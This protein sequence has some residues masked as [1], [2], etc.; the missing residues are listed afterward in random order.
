MYNCSISSGQ[1]P[2][3]K[4]LD[5][6]NIV[7]SKMDASTSKIDDIKQEPLESLQKVYN[8]QDESNPD[9]LKKI[10]ALR[11]SIE[12][13]SFERV[14]K[15][16]KKLCDTDT[17]KKQKIISSLVPY[18]NIS[19]LAFAVYKG[20]QRIL[21][22]FMSIFKGNEKYLRSELEKVQPEGTTLLHIAARKNSSEII[23]AYL[24]L[25]EP[26]MLDTL[27]STKDIEER[28]LLFVAAENG[29]KESIVF[30]LEKLSDDE[31]I[32]YCQEA[33]YKGDTPFSIAIRNKK[34]ESLEA[35]LSCNPKVSIAQH[36]KLTDENGDNCLHSVVGN[37]E[38]MN[39]LF[40]HLTADDAESL[41][42][43][44][45]KNQLGNTPL[46]AAIR[47]NQECIEAL[48]N[49]MAA[50]NLDLGEGDFIGFTPLH[51]AALNGNVNVFK[52]YLNN[53][54]LLL[55]KKDM[56]GFSPIDWCRLYQEN[57]II[58]FL[59]TEY[60]SDID[61]NIDSDAR[62]III[63]HKTIKNKFIAYFK[64]E[65]K[66][67]E[68]LL[69]TGSRRHLPFCFEWNDIIK[70]WGIKKLNLGLAILHAIYENDESDKFYRFLKIIAQ[71][72]EKSP[73]LGMSLIDLGYHD[74]ADLMKN[75]IG[76]T[77]WF[78]AEKINGSFAKIATQGDIQKRFKLSS[79]YSNKIF[80]QENFRSVNTWG[81]IKLGKRKRT[82][83]NLSP[84][85]ITQSSQENLDK[86]HLEIPSNQDTNLDQNLKAY[87]PV[88]TTSEQIKEFIQTLKSSA[89]SQF[90]ITRDQMEDSRVVKISQGENGE[91][92]Y[93]DSH[94]PF[95]LKKK[96]SDDQLV[97]LLQYSFRR[98]S[99][100]IKL[101]FCVL[102][103]NSSN[104]STAKASSPPKIEL[105][106][107]TF[108]Q[109][110]AIR[111]VSGTQGRAQGR[112]KKDRTEE[113]V[114]LLTERQPTGIRYNANK[115][116][117]WVEGGV[118]NAMALDFAKNYFKMKK[119]QGITKET[120]LQ[121]LIEKIKI[122]SEKYDLPY[123]QSSA[124]VEEFR[125]QQEA[126][127][128]IE[129]DTQA[130]NIDFSLAKVQSVASF[131]SLKITRKTKET[132]FLSNECNFST[133]KK[134]NDQ[135]AALT[136]GIHLIR[137]IDPKENEKLE[138]QGHSMI[139]IKEPQGFFYYDSNNGVE[140]IKNNVSNCIHNRLKKHNEVNDLKSFR[141]Y[142]LEDENNDPE[143]GEATNESYEMACSL[144]DSDDNAA[145]TET[146]YDSAAT[147]ETESDVE[148]GV[149]FEEE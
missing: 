42:V 99:G 41:E 13:R 33:N 52:W 114:K 32:K 68:E 9:Y 83:S 118:C 3:Q 108:R 15:S 2:G 51:I 139:F 111:L 115:I 23:R 19:F 112:T 148:E 54:P 131:Y 103:F 130:K 123:Q 101:N 11:M 66:I 133:L 80:K 96:I 87:T 146:D 71:W 10:T 6:K 56:Y 93:Y 14:K 137:F 26:Q 38:M 45:A 50:M 34:K 86:I 18:N 25:I 5:T 39:E 63:D 109:A 144:T 65:K 143:K 98:H 60:S 20:D 75:W 82:D 31:K 47:G 29:S 58:D 8:Q 132:K 85:D 43:F 126:L 69:Y 129:V 90:L 21:N 84:R 59:Q 17:D 124:C 120:S 106:E 57:S 28:T 97:D 37:Q 74:L 145:T 110:D 134:I 53:A 116:T 91:W 102:S 147:T 94:L 24:D 140:H 61:V 30:L 72:D 81:V 4:Q 12:K 1:L 64:R 36:V 100:T 127:N 88:K 138:K 117:G 104:S 105:T 7:T 136:N 141:F 62:F 113:I 73:S 125:T 67:D 128:C 49:K 76:D 46:H 149:D 92:N 121:D 119:D 22:L 79:L 48:L 16:L 107:E 40:Q 142:T 135:I 95:E 55:E 122:F 27:L 35:L 89:K 77:W 70:K 78:Q 44:T